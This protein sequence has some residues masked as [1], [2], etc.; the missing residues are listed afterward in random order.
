MAYNVSDT[1]K[2]GSEERPPGELSL[3]LSSARSFMATDSVLAKSKLHPDIARELLIQARAADEKTPLSIRVTAPDADP[4]C[5]DLLRKAIQDHFSGEAL[6]HTQQIGD[7]F[8]LA[9]LS[10]VLGLFIVVVLLAF[11]QLIPDDASRLMLGV[12]ES[13]TIFAWVA[14]WRP[15]ELWFYAH[16]PERHWRRLALRL[17]QAEVVPDCDQSLEQ[18]PKC[19]CPVA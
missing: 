18:Q 15:A 10:T 12:R 5:L 11:A 4:L 17:S 13:L 8:R 7:I 3:S 2:A 14:M 19:A 16:L 6:I 1:T 9:K